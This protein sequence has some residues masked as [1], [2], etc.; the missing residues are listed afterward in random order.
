MQSIH[1]PLSLSGATKENKPISLH[2]GDIT[3]VQ[4]TSG[5][6][7]DSIN[8]TGV[9]LSIEKKDLDTQKTVHP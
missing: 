1:F 8:H 9:A 4:E 2:T 3:N 5:F 6:Y 7:A